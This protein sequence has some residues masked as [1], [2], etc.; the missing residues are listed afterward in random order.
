MIDNEF[1]SNL[2]NIFTGILKNENDELSCMTKPELENFWFFKYNSKLSIECN[3]YEFNKMLDLYKRKCR[4]WE[5]IHNGNSCVVERV[6]DEYLIPKINDF[7][8]TMRKILSS[9]DQLKHLK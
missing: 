5:E 3:M 8:K 7:I 9:E 1:E 4:R 6:R 2:N